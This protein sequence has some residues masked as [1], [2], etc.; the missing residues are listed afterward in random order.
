MT[1]SDIIN[2]IANDQIEPAMEALQK[3]TNMGNTSIM[4]KARWN[5][6]QKEIN[7]GTINNENAKL[8]RNK[9]VNALLNS[10]RNL[11][12]DVTVDM[13]MPAIGPDENNNR[14]STGQKTVFIS[15]NHKDFEQAEKVWKYLKQNG[16]RVLIDREEMKAGEDIKAFINRCIKSSDV[17]LSLVSTNSLLSGWVGLESVLTLTGEGIADK[18]FIACS[19]QSDFFD[20]SFMRKAITKI[21]ERITKI[22]EELKWRRENGIGIDDIEEELKRNT[23]LKSKLPEIIANLKGRLT[24]DISG[25]HFEPA[26]K[27]VVESISR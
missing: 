12:D 26:M 24:I 1:K 15:Y 16:F 17:T 11:S 13:D 9:I 7:N 4:L 18:K 20:M 6:L 2:L 5:S 23:Q 27:R 10:A 19:L 3:A 25:D 22:D 21:N 8:E 14:P